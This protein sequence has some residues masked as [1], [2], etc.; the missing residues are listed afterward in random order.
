MTTTANLA[1]RLES[2]L[3]AHRVVA[4]GAELQEYASESI[5]PGAIVRPASA[6]E[7][8]E[9]V[10]YAATEKLAIVAT[11]SRSKLNMGMPPAR[12][13][14]AL[15]MTGLHDIAH[16]DPS[17]LTLS[18]DAGMP[19]REL[20]NV[21]AEKRQFLPL[22]VPCFE[23]TTV[24]GALASGIDSASRN[25]YGTSRDFLIGAEFIDGKGAQCKSGG[26]VVK[27][28]TGYDL[29]KLLVG[30][31]GTLAVI[32]RL[33][34]RTFPQPQ[35]SG[36]HLASFTDLQGAS[37]Y[38]ADIENSGLP[39]AVVETL[40]PDMAAVTPGVQRGNNQG[41]TPDFDSSHWWVYASYEGSEAVVARIARDLQKLSAEAAAVSNQTLD[42]TSDAHL[43]GIL[44]EAFD[45]L[46][47]TSPNVALFRIVLPQNKPADLAALLG[48]A[49]ESSL[50]SALLVRAAGIVY[51][52]L[53]AEN[54]DDAALHFLE[55]ASARIFSLANAAQ[56]QA[57]VLHS[58]AK[59][60]PRVNV[61]GPK[62]PD[63]AMMQ[64]V[65]DSFDPQHIL[66]PGRFVGG[67]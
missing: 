15:D 58:S 30:S 3:G 7:A 27:N 44:R 14:I 17:D 32:T 62:R 21:L 18:V 56:G 46:R 50:R 2:I 39:L 22:A 61:W 34:F 52:T 29:H 25:Q 40:S 12:Y 4:A 51:F 66:A 1:I 53:L 37:L 33:N 23:T 49:H 42:V 57:T 28:V 38:R 8:A 48:V 16:Y 59:L 47:W 63:F 60:K 31:L 11:G 5:L 20:S 54:E 67:I 9:V 41:F 35:A 45:W 55:T 65:K 10:R 19:L 64:R 24:G 6:Q 43:R 26:R 13:D 36:G